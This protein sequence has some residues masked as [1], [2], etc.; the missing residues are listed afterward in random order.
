MNATLSLY[1]KAF[2]RLLFPEYCAV[3]GEVLRYGEPIMCHHC[4]LNLPLVRFNDFTDNPAA[5]LF[6]HSVEVERVVSLY[7]YMPGSP[8]K[9]P[10]I[11]MKYHHRHDIGRY[12]GRLA[13]LVWQPKGFFEGIDYIVPVPLHAKRIAYRGYNQSEM[14]ARGIS[15]ITGIPVK[16]RCIKRNSNTATQTH[17]N[18]LD[19]WDTMR[20]IFAL[21]PRYTE[22]LEGKHLL[23]VDDVLTTGATTA[24]CA[25]ELLTIKGCRVSILTLA[26]AHQ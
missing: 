26:M 14:I 1:L 25:R 16:T 3:C 20:R 6:W 15:S 19:R 5:R 23:L 9:G 18:R 4:E 17:K 13:A 10:I 8:Y 11:K 12:M 2:L 21:V 24:S 7:Y 22:G